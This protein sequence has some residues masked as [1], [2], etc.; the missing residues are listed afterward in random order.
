MNFLTAKQLLQM[1]NSWNIDNVAFKT[2]AQI[3]LY[4]LWTNLNHSTIGKSK[5]LF[6]TLSPQYDRDLKTVAAMCLKL[7]Q[8]SESNPIFKGTKSGHGEE[9][10]E[11]D[12]DNLEKVSMEF[13]KLLGIFHISE[14][15]EGEVELV[16]LH[17][18]YIELLAAISCLWK[19][20]IQE[21]MLK[22]IIKPER[23]GKMQL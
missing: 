2:E 18:S 10:W 12:D 14:P 16:P 17:R 15:E 1:E 20:R 13:L 4:F 8:N 21:E 7:T 23:K 11:W 6:T 22:R 9:F 5:L 3:A 19:G